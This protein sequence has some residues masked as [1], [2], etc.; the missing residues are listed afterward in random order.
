MSIDKR[1][2][3]AAFPVLKRIAVRIVDSAFLIGALGMLVAAAWTWDIHAGL[4]AAGLALGVLDFEFG[5]PT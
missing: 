4:A 3:S 5:D 2:Y 1:R